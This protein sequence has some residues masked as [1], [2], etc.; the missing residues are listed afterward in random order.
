MSYNIAFK[1][2]VEGVDAYVEVG[3]C[4]A[5][6]TWNVRKII[7][8]STGLPWRNEE[9]NGLC[10]DVI[11]QIRSGLAELR[12]RPD[13]YKQYEAS[14]GWGSVAGTARFFERILEDWDDLVWHHEELAAVATF[15]IS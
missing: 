10:V 13:A 7:E 15:W 4:G 2:K 8:M 9:N 14:N 11:P 12:A 6:I 3:D 1:V 5:N